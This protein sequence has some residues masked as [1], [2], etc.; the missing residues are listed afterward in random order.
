MAPVAP[1]GQVAHVA[2]VS[3]FGPAV[4]DQEEIREE[5]ENR[6][7]FFLHFILSSFE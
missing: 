7:S 3:H 5:S 2:P 1:V 4:P 6:V